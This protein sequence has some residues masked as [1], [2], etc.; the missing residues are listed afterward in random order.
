V[1]SSA[2]DGRSVFFAIQFPLSVQ[3]IKTLLGNAT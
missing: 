3:N 2:F 1:Q